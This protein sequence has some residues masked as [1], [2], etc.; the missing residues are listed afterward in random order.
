MEVPDKIL[1]PALVLIVIIWI[2][3]DYINVK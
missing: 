1:L 2:I 3:G